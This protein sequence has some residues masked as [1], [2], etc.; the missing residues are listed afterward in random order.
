MSPSKLVWI[1]QSPSWPELHFDAAKFAGALREARLAQG[2]LLGKAAALQANALPLTQRDVWA[3]DA[4][5]TAAIE[6]ETLDLAA[7]RSS[8]AR[9][10][11]I[12][13][14]F[15]AAVPRNIEALL[16][17]ME[18]AT[19]NWATDLTDERLF[20]WQ[21]SLFP[22]G[23]SSIRSNAVGHY[24][25]HADP[26]QIV[27][28]PVGKEVVHYEAPASAVVA[29][30]MR[31]F[32]DWFNQTRDGASLDGI[33]RAG[34][35]HVWFESIH[36]FEDGNG[37]IGRAIVDMAL[38]QD[39]RAPSRMF[40]MA[41]RMRTD[42]PTY[43]EALNHAQRGSGDVTQ[44]LSWFI[45]AFRA[46]CRTSAQTIDES[47]ARAHFWSEHRD[48]TINERQRKVLNR[49][50]EAGPGRF[51]GGMTA[52]KYQALTGTTKVTASRDLAELALTGLL[53]RE[54]SG[55]STYYNLPMPEWAWFRAPK[56]Q[57]PKTHED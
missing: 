53:L 39:V 34:L 47:I 17:I 57:T 1:W 28:G 12:T 13:S 52:R 29:A 4:V 24:R 21:A 14:A 9:R 43:Y 30:E 54:G 5:A 50:L 2:M 37:R 46:S 42:Q 3:D 10:L 35:A 40:G 31:K 19:G 23:R 49:M 56:R 20:R 41:S 6:G 27:S 15:T 51:E 25:I 8:V 26:M 48:T 16:D 18:D 45:N 11:G 22:G 38:A 32:L 33:V 55:R 7:V 44:W 36:P